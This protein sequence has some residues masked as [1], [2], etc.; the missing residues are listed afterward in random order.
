M[1]NLNQ[2]TITQ[3][4]IAGLVDTPDARLKELMTSLVQHLHAFA[5]FKRPVQQTGDAGFDARHQCIT[6]CCRQEIVEQIDVGPIGVHASG[7]GQTDVVNVE[8]GC[9]L[10]R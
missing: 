8:A 5:V 1:R 4:V 2:D 10:L 3:A 7:K 6:F 9:E